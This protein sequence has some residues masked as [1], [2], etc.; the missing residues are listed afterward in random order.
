MIKHSK[1]HHSAW[2]KHLSFFCVILLVISALIGCNSY[3]YGAD[4]DALRAELTEEIAALKEENLAAQSTIDSLTADYEAAKSEISAL[5]S[6]LQSAEQK[7]D[8]L[9]TNYEAALQKINAL[10]ESIESDNRDFDSIKHN[11]DE[12]M[13]E[14]EALTAAYEE[15]I[16]EL[17]AI[18]ADH[19]EAEEEIE[20]L[21][22]AY[23][24]A[25]LEIES[26]RTELE[27]LRDIVIP[28]KIRIYIDQGHNPTGYKNSG[29][30]GNGLHEQD[31]TFNIGKLLAEILESDGRFEICLSRPT[32]DTVL[33][34][35]QP[36][37]LE[38]RVAGARAF[39][40]DFFISL[41][42]NSFETDSPSGIEVHVAEE[43][44]ESYA[45]GN[46]LR[47]GMIASTGMNDRGMKLSPN[48]YV[49][50]NATMPAAL[51]EMGFISNEG[52][53]ALLSG[54]PELFVEGIYSGILTYFEL[55]AI[56]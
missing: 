9:R 36:S 50:K 39:E 55:P 27:E 2:Q 19:A 16:G 33:G 25:T 14:F 56:S 37:S 40:A 18:R 10:K 15:L 30:S 6:K 38:A 24:E 3:D 7:T 29:A 5:Q 1:V 45:F 53:A 4:I 54:S 51:L 11:Y 32:A 8:T 41:H 43:N 47:E 42:V 17:D 28:R 52:D 46:A 34:T 35:D 48:L 44:S 49:L 23:D 20:S 26:L 13:A 22:A 21:R 12:A 31:I